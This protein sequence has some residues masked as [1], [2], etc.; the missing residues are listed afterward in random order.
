L[1]TISK[2]NFYK[3]LF[4][5]PVSPE[6]INFFHKFLRTI[7]GF[8]CFYGCTFPYDFLKN[9]RII[10]WLRDM[11]LLV[12]ATGSVVVK[13]SENHLNTML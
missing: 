4:A 6:G 2:E 3:V 5:P 1:N 11:F 12:W 8:R 10:T 13:R 9:R 7:M